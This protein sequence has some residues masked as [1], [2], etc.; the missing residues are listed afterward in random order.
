MRIPFALASIALLA[1][2]PAFA[3]ADA[4]DE[5]PPKKIREVYLPVETHDEDSFK[6]VDIPGEH[7]RAH[8]MYIRGRTDAKYAPMIDERVHFKRDL[9]KSIGLEIAPAEAAETTPK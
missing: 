9:A 8:Q 3:Q 5:A 1:A 2:P 7:R 6:P 4:G